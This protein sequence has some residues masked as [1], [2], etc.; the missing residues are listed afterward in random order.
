MVLSNIYEEIY[1]IL[2]YMDKITVMKVPEMI[3]K[4]I[5]KLIIKKENYNKEK[6]KN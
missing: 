2:S 1:E 5:L 4:N 3:L 6:N